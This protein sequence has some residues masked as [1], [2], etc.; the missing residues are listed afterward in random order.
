MK[1][2]TLRVAYNFFSWS[3]I[4]FSLIKYFNKITELLKTFH[5]KKN[6]LIINKIQGHVELIVIPRQETQNK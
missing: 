3:E 5:S 2:H 6:N 1:V 4:I